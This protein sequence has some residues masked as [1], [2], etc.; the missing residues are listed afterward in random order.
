[1]KR[2][3][4]TEE[5]I[6]TILKDHERGVLVAELARQHGVTEQT[7]HLSLEG[8]VRGYGGVGSQ[9]SPGPG[10]RKCPAEETAG[11]K[12]PRQCRPQGDRL[13]KVVTPEAKRRAVTYLVTGGWLSQRHACRLLGLP[14]SLARY[15]AKP[16]DDE[17]LRARVQALATCCPCYGYLMLHAPLRQE[18]LVV[19]RKLPT[20]STP[21]LGFRSVPAGASDWCGLECRCH[22]PIAPT[23]STGF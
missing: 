8:Q 2:N 3:R 12:R 9:A 16:C 23:I 17:P 22:F 20:G 7:G 21:R 13:G 6:I 11:G 15:Q 19:N 1:M 14:R 5:Q 4:H 10:G 18:G